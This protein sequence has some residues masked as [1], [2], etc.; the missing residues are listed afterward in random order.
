[1]SG[2]SIDWLDLREAADRR[3]RDNALRD[4]T[5][6]WLEAGVASQQNPVVVDLGAGTG[7]TLRAFTSPNQQPL[8]WRLVDNDTALLDEADRRHGAIH[9]IER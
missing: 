4:Q 5:I 6:E 2:F 8:T 7:S 3:A 9:R 1:M